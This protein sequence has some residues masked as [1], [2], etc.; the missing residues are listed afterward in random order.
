MKKNDVIEGNGELAK[1][2]AEQ[3]AN[4]GM[5]VSGVTDDGGTGLEYVKQFQPDVVV[6]GMVLRSIDGFGVLDKLKDLPGRRSVIAVGNFSDDATIDLILQK[7]ARSYMMRP[8]NASQVAARLGRC[9]YFHEQ[10]FA[11]NG[12]VLLGNRDLFHVDEFVE[13]F[14]RLRK[15]VL[16]A[17]KHDGHA[18]KIFVFRRARA[19]AFDVE[20]AAGKQPRYARQNAA[21]VCNECGYNVFFHMFH[22]LRFW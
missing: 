21:F 22:R 13:L 19:D 9:P 20:S 3:L 8:V 1:V 11:E 2:L 18:R 15:G 14:G 16:V 4:R 10:Q 5:E 17:R 7:G 12:I 6:V